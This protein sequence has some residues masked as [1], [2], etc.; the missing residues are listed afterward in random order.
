MAELF[1]DN[2]CNGKRKMGCDYLWINFNCE[3]EN[4]I[5]E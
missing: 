3:G 2:Y 1:L 5:T 4:G